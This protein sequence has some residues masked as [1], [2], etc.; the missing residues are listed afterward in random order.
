MCWDTLPEASRFKI[1]AESPMCVFIQLNVVGVHGHCLQTPL[2]VSSAMTVVW[3]RP[4]AR[5][6]GGKER[7]RQGIHLC[8]LTFKLLQT[9][10]R[11]GFGR[12][13]A[14]SDSV[15]FRLKIAP[16]S[17]IELL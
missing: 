6:Q 12:T 8:A 15:K 17:R 13:C 14:K 16:M 1:S 3:E 11:V 7:C 4:H 10:L 9:S 5:G 2:S